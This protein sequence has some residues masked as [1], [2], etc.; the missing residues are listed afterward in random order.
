MFLLD[1]N[2]VSELRRPEKAD[3]HVVDWAERSRS[4]PAYLSAVTILELELGMLRLARRDA[5]QSAQLKLWIDEQIRLFG[6]DILPVDTQVARRCASLYVPDKRS[7]RDAYIAA[8]ALVHGLTVVT[9]NTRDFEPTGVATLNP[10][11][12]G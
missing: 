9:R 2:V 1:T 12:P 3:T 6:S 7:E 11:L 5:I 8:T 4:K 10:W